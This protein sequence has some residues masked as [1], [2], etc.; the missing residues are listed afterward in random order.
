MEKLSANSQSQRISMF[1][2]AL[3][4]IFQR[5]M[6]HMSRLDPEESFLI[7]QSYE[8]HHNLGCSEVFFEHLQNCD[9]IKMV[10][11]VIEIVKNWEY[12]HAHEKKIGK[13][14]QCFMENIQD[15]QLRSWIFTQMN[16]GCFYDLEKKII[17]PKSKK[18]LIFYLNLFLGIV[19]IILFY[20]DIFKDILFFRILGH[21]WTNVLVK[22][23]S[24]LLLTFLKLKYFIFLV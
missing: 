2:G 23:I 5:D 8:Q 15:L 6:T 20:F 14:Y 10:E 1:D 13:V 17:S 22:C 7:I 12:K 16:R 19:G 3:I 9:N 18:M 24:F 11:E 21:L 4:T